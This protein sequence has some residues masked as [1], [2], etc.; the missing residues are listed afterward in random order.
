MF[1]EHTVKLS[2][3][4]RFKFV[5]LRPYKIKKVPSSVDVHGLYQLLHS[6]VYRNGLK[7]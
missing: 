3:A 4:M 6:Q 7:L 5:N 1:S 2:C